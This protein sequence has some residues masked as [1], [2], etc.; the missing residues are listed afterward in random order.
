[1]LVCSDMCLAVCQH[2][3]ECFTYSNSFNNPHNSPV[4]W[5][6]FMRKQTEAET[7]YIIAPNRK[8]GGSERSI[9]T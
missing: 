6:P 8:L 1:M 9:H 7:V 5:V 4:R 3:S 2:C